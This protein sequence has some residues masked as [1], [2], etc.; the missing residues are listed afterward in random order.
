MP[1][2]SYKIASISGPNELSTTGALEGH[3][4]A[5]VKSDHEEA[6]AQVYSEI[7]ANRLAIFLG[8]PVA[9]GVPAHLEDGDHSIRYASLRASERNHEFYD[10]TA[11]DTRKNT[12]HNPE[13]K[14]LSNDF[15]NEISQIA[16]FDYWIGN[17]DRELNFKAELSKEDRGVIFA[18]DHGNSLLSCASTITKSL[19]KL[20]DETFPSFHLFDDYI[21]MHY[22]K[23]M[24]DRINQIPEWAIENAVVMND[25]VGCVSLADQYALYDVLIQRKLYLENQLNKNAVE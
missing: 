8:L 25:V 21:E 24:M 18:L 22:A 17:E 19:E 13:M 12:Y 23:I 10:F 11:E 5:I 16:V 6:I 20:Q 7:A 2:L 1:I 3:L 4:S 9:T 15:P 14:K